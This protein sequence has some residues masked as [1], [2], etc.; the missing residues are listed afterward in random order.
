MG[1]MLRTAALAVG[2]LMV[3]C[4]GGEKVDK[5]ADAGDPDGSGIV[6]GVTGVVNPLETP[7]AE[8]TGTLLLDI[9]H[10]DRAINQ[11]AKVK[12]QAVEGDAR[13]KGEGNQDFELP[14]GLYTA[15]IEY[16]ESD[17]SGKHKGSLTGLKVS[18]GVETRYSVKV[19]APIGLLRFK[20]ARVVAGQREPQKV[21]D[22]AELEVFRAE[23]D[24]DLTGAFWTGPAG[25]WLA[26]P[27]GTYHAKATLKLE[28]GPVTEWYRDLV[29]EEKL[30]RNDQDITLARDDDGVRIDAFNFGKDVN[31][32]ASVYF[33]SPGADTQTAVAKASGAAGKLVKVDPGTYDIMV[34]YQPDP[35]QPDL[36]GS[37]L[38]AGFVVPERGGVRRQ[39]DIERELGL[40]RVSVKAGEED[41]NDAVELRVMREG[42]DLDAGSPVLDEV[43]V[44][45][46]P[47]P[48]GTYDIYLTLPEAVKNPAAPPRAVEWRQAAKPAGDDDDSARGDDD[49]SAK[50]DAPA[51]GA[52][53]PAEATEGAAQ[54]V[55]G[56]AKPAGGAAPGGAAAGKP[57]PQ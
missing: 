22:Q 8:G 45:E 49:D 26:L 52:A 33:F 39:V 20:F 57:D 40:L 10:T 32:H 18:A 15:E 12:I 55:E 4:G 6:T 3:G 44:S 35:R 2:L 47:L 11:K 54:P 7:S 36:S 24:P 48:A 19:A 17:L 27:V 14:P 46:H 29:I 28:D 30:A 50:A 38:L 23:D 41:V 9:F 31:D 34:V 13:A 5:S 42:A 43:G 16:K 1:R 53:Q 37:Q 21:T 56:A 51:E 25:E